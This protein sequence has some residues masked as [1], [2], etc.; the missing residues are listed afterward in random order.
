MERMEQETESNRADW[1]RTLAPVV[2]S[3][4]DVNK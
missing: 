4:P 1:S 3:V 2:T